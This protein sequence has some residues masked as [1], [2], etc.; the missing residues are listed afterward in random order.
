VESLAKPLPSR[1][2]VPV[3]HKD[4]PPYDHIK[5]YRI[6]VIEVIDFV[7]KVSRYQAEHNITLPIQSL[8]SKDVQEE[9]IVEMNPDM[10]Y[11]EFVNLHPEEVLRCIEER[12][13]PQSKSAFVTALSKP[14]ELDWPRNYSIQVSNFHMA[15]KKYNVYKNYFMNRFNLV[16]QNNERNV[17]NCSDQKQDDGLIYFFLKGID[18]FEYPRKHYNDHKSKFQTI[19][20]EVDREA[21]LIGKNPSESEKF[22]KFIDLFYELMAVDYNMHKENRTLNEKVTPS[23]KE[24]ENT[25]DTKT[26]TKPKQ[27]SSNVK[28]SFVKPKQYS[29]PAK[30]LYYMQ[31]DDSDEDDDESDVDEQVKRDARKVYIDDEGYESSGLPHGY[32]DTLD[33]EDEFEQQLL[34]QMN[35]NF[36]TTTPELPKVCFR[37]LFYEKCESGDKC[38]WTHKPEDLRSGYKHYANLLAKSK[39]KPQNFF[40]G[41]KDKM[42]STE[43]APMKAPAIPDFR[44]AKVTSRDKPTGILRHLALNPTDVQQLDVSNT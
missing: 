43:R 17:P 1:L 38:K 9:I 3:V 23:R 11:Q 31:E 24:Y 37:E 40:V 10:T 32:V 35:S 19:F 25:P 22:R 36:K 26:F 42:D 2:I 16:A 13:R 39:Y 4:V 8:L 30:K 18:N 14:I 29:T 27:Y 33:S 34:T 15:Y 12:A 28:R 5:L 21:R 41:Y 6:K 44:N 7:E 20:K